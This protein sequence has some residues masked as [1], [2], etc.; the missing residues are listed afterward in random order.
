MTTSVLATTI[1][2]TFAA[3][4]TLGVYLTTAHFHTRRLAII[5]STLT[6]LFFYALHLT[7]THLAS[8]FDAP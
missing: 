2:L 1:L 3:L 6:L 8:S 7:L 4:T 5:L